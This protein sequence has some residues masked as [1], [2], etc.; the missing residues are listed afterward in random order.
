[1]KRSE[2]AHLPPRL[3]RRWQRRIGLVLAALLLAATLVPTGL[4]FL[5]M[6]GV[7]HPVCSPGPSPGQYGLAPEEVR[8]PSR[9]GAD[10]RGYFFRGENGATIILSPALGQDRSGWMHEVDVLVRSGYNVLTFDSRPCTG[11]A[12]HSL[13]YWEA[14][15][16]LD[17]VEYLR[18]RGDIDLARIG[19][20]GFSQAG[21]S[22][23]FAAARSPEIRAVVAEGGYVDYAAQTIA[24]GRTQDP[25]MVLFGLGAQLGYRAATGMDIRV[26]RLLDLIPGIA[27]R[28]ILLVYGSA[29]GTLA[30]AR[31]AEALGDHVRL[32][33]V[34]GATHGSYLWS[35]GE[36]AFRSHVA[37]FFDEALSPLD[38]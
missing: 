8:V 29:E 2:S 15:D 34:P 18:S 35:A 26:L 25:F 1:M 10:F 21:S 9:L 22:N 17:A 30:W 13:G 16:I 4:G 27:P 23:I 6:W 38:R 37:G 12:P 14:D 5:T 7:T 19:L 3:L 32:W 20:H 28:P 31:Q 11:I 36:D 24:L 33:E